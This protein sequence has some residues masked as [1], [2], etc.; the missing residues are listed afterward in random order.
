MNTLAGKSQAFTV[1][2]ETGVSIR[3]LVVGRQVLCAVATNA[4]QKNI[5]FGIYLIVPAVGSKG[6][7]L[8]FAVNIVAGRT[9]AGAR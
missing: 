4:G 7:V 6:N 8:L 1:R 5:N 2:A 9:L 3:R